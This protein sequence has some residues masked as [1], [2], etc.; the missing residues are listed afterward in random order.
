MVKTHFQVHLYQII[1]N[2]SSGE[3]YKKLIDQKSLYKSVKISI[4]E[5]KF[6]VFYNGIKEQPARQIYSL[7]DMYETK[8]DKPELET[9][10][11]EAIDSCIKE[12]MMSEFFKSNRSK[13]MEASIWEFN[14]ELNDQAKFEDGE[15]T[16]YIRGKK[17][18][19][20]EGIIA[21]NALISQGLITPS[22]AAN[23]MNMTE[24]E[25]LKAVK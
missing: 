4:P 8:T 12:G 3:E 10:I 15:Q 7:S 6:V 23:S 13:I 18:G 5:P 21:L 20:L 9:A 1:I 14:Q 25:F 2:E 24:E 17:E 11:S 19:Q 22:E 16:G